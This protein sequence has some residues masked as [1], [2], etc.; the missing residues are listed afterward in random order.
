MEAEWMSYPP[1]NGNPKKDG[2]LRFQAPGAAVDYPYD[3]KFYSNPFE[4]FAENHPFL[5]CKSGGTAGYDVWFE[6]NPK[7]GKALISIAQNCDVGIEKCQENQAPKRKREND[8]NEEEPDK[9]HQVLGP[10]T[11]QV[12]KKEAESLSS[13]PRR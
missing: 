5:Y 4:F 6:L 2:F 1:A 7:S 3:E 13:I 9:K 11:E 12:V 10:F 8:E